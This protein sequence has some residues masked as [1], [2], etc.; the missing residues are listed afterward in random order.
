VLKTVSGCQVFFNQGVVFMAK[1]GQGEGSIAKRSDG[2]YWA[3]ITIGKTKDGKQKR[4]AFYGKTRKEVSERMTEALN[5]RNKGTYIEPTKMTV[6]EWLDIWLRDYKKLSVKP[7]TYITYVV[8]IENH[9][10][11][12]IGDYKLKDLRSDMIQRLINDLIISGLSP[13]T[14]IGVYKVIRVAVEQAYDNELITKSVANKIKLPTTEKKAIRVFTQQEQDIFVEAAKTTYTG[15]VFILDL[16]TGLRIGELL[17]LRWSDINFDDGMLN[18][19]RTLNITKNFDDPNS[20]W[21]KSYGTPKTKSSIRSIPLYP[22]IINFLKKLRKEQMQ[23]RLRMGEAYENNDLVFATKLG[24]P[25]DPRNMQ[26]TF[27]SIIKKAG[28]SGVHIHCLR[29]TYATRGLE[30]GIELIV[31]QELLGHASLKMTADLYE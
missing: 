6:G 19:N 14:V 11:P 2:T 13:D 16:G 1:K 30:N 8:R 26:R 9:I 5:D 21:Y 25:L 15:E 7:T 24:N 18:V 28:L 27:A 29:H 12:R 31:M 17:A 20:K 23:Q 3:R 10:K 4:K 22:K